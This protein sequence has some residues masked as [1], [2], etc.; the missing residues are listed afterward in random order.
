MSQ[1]AAGKL[2]YQYDRLF[3]SRQGTGVVCSRKL[4]N[5]LDI[6]MIHPGSDSDDSY[7]GRL[8]NLDFE[9]SK[10]LA[11]EA[12]RPIE[13]QVGQKVCDPLLKKGMLLLWKTGQRRLT[14]QKQ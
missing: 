12:T 8:F 14:I 7:T 10:V 4:P 9:G 1:E 5:E 3:L 13:V 6:L 2:T 11:P